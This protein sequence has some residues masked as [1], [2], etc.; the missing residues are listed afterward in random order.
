MMC[1][2]QFSL[3]C[4]GRPAAVCLALGRLLEAGV[5]VGLDPLLARDRRSRLGHEHR[6]RLGAGAVPQRLAVLPLDRN[7]AR[8][9]VDAELGQPLAD[10]AGRRAPL[11]L[12]QLEHGYVNTIW[13]PAASS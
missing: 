8:D 6:N 5:E 7:L 2:L 10:A 13:A 1:L 12:V 3:V 11:G 4:P 9:E